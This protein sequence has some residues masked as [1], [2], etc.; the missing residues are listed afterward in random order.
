MKITRISPQTKDPLRENIYL[1]GKFGFGI[2]A[3]SRFDHRLKIGQNLSESEIHDLVFQDQA[4][5]LFTSAQMFLSYRPRSEKEVRQ[6]LKRKLDRGEWVEPDGILDEVTRRLKKLKL[7]DD[8]EFTRWWIEQRQKFKPR[9]ERLLRAE[10]HG[11]GIPRE[12][13]DQALYAYQ[14]PKLEIDRV[15]AKVAPRYA[16]LSKIEFRNKLG[17]YLA[18]RGYSWDEISSVVDRLLRSV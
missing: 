9:G 18:R 14:A 17:S 5:K 1:D 15:A 12:V 16:K 3:E 6:N 2:A 10:L 4:G 11:K 7:V 8:G 13:I